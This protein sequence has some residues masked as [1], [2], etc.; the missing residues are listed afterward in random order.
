MMRIKK[1]KLKKGNIQKNNIHDNGSDLNSSNRDLKFKKK[2]ELL[3]SRKSLRLENSNNFNN[4]ENNENNDKNK[5]DN[6]DEIINKLKKEKDMSFKGIFSRFF[7]KKEIL[8]FPLTSP[9]D[10]IPF[11]ISFS[12]F[13]LSANFIFLSYCLC[14]NNK[15]VHD[16]FLKNGNLGI[17]I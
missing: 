15:N 1:K 2:N 6:D 13:L 10:Y 17:Y 11:F 7:R 4:N 14:F 8:L 9:K 3:D 16:R 12:V 5:N